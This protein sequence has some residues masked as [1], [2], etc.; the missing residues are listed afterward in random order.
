M[1]LLMSKAVSAIL[2]S[3]VTFVNPTTPKTLTFNASVFVTAN[4]K[5]RLSIEK[6]TEE[7]LVVFLRDNQHDILFRQVVP[8]K[9]YKSALLFSVSDLSDG[10]YEL[11]IK[12]KEG[13][14]RRQI[15]LA[16]TP[17]QA[18]SRVIAMN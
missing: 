12:S 4:N 5:V 15:K 2:L 6:T 14:I 13:S 16:T 9:E 8:K 1:F 10:D 11:E 7:T 18:P 17:T 3:A